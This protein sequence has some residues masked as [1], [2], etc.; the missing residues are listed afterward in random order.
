M[1]LSKKILSSSLF[2]ILSTSGMAN[3]QLAEPTLGQSI[4]VVCSACHGTDGISH[5]SVPTLK[6]LSFNSLEKSL[7]R[8]RSGEK[9][10][11]IMNRIA[12]GYT[13]DEITAVS[14]YFGSMR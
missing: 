7:L 11:T 5:G 13:P 3:Q 14:D 6:G 4:G 8:Y 9:K 12:K 2:L 10:G 1:K